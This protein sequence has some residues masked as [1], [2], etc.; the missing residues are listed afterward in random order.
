MESLQKVNELVDE[1]QKK[2][3]KMNE[4]SQNLQPD[5]L[6]NKKEEIKQMRKD[7]DDLKILIEQQ[8]EAFLKQ[9]KTQRET[10]NQM[11]K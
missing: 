5:Q 2:T 6:G 4:I 1:Y 11:K 8:K 9:I 3:E 7:L 10:F